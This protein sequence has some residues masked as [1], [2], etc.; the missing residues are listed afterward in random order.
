MKRWASTLLLA[1]AAI[2]AAGRVEAVSYSYVGT[3]YDIGGTFYPGGT[4]PYVVAPWRS[5][6]AAKAFDIDGNDVYGTAGYAMF[7]TQFNYPNAGCC[8]SSVPFA[9]ATYPNLVSTPNWI[10]GTQNLTTNK[11]GGWGYALADDPTLTNGPRN[12]NWGQSLAPP[13]NG[14]VPYVKIGILDGNDIF[15]NNPQSTPAGR[16]AFT[17][18]ANAPAVIR[19][20]VMTDGLDATQWAASEVVLAEVSGSPTPSVVGSVSSGTVTRDRFI[21]IHTFDIVGAQP[22]DSFAIM[23]R[24][25]SGGFGA[26]SAVTFD[27]IPEPAS[28]GIALTALGALVG[29]RRRLR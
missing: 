24:A 29:F 7:A 1:L 14:Q 13:V 12:Y 23:A 21:D 27:V 8:G 4:A 5:S 20:G 26:I 19:V 9:S 28:I 18:G 25:A 22:G 3:D 15:G 17:V 2:V 11:V 10:A 16:W 6:D